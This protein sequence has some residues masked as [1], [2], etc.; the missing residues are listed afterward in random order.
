MK[1]IFVCLISI[2]TLFAYTIPSIAFLAYNGE[3]WIVCVLENGKITE[4]QLDE[5]PHSFDYNFKND[6]IVYVGADSKL[7]FYVHGDERELQL[8][9]KHSGF[10]QPSFLCEDN[11]VYAVEL[12]NKNSRSTKIVQIDLKDDSL[13]TVVKQNS[14]QFEPVE[15]DERS[16]LFTNLVCNQGCAKL[17]QEIWIKNL[18]TGLSEQV[19]L[20]NAFST[21][22][23]IHYGSHM[24]FFNSNRYDNYN[25]WAK[26]IDDDARAFQV[27]FSEAIDTDPVAIN[28]NSFLFIRNNGSKQTIMYGD[29][30]GQLYEIKLLKEYN[31]IRQLK[32][33]RCD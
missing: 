33:Q 5:E 14:S 3:E 32:V 18:V 7:R 10:T 31:K 28:D 2:Y 29:L 13:Q 6:Q 21:N 9:Y 30:Q 12:I 23:S 16:I 26:K 20:L 11:L 25:I 22:P 19:T 1:I 17:I 15:C 8:P 27:T 24:M 4:I